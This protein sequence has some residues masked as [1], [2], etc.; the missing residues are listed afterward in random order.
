MQKVRNDSIIVIYHFSGLLQ[1]IGLSGSSGPSQLTRLG[2]CSS[3]WGV[4]G[5]PAQAV[6][7]S[8]GGPYSRSLSVD[9]VNAWA[10]NTPSICFSWSGPFVSCSFCGSAASVLDDWDGVVKSELDSLGVVEPES[11]TFASGDLATMSSSLAAAA[12]L[13]LVRALRLPCIIYINAAGSWGPAHQAVLGGIIINQGM[14]VSSSNSGMG[15]RKPLGADRGVSLVYWSSH[16]RVTRRGA[17]DHCIY[18]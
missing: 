9:G 18:I 4:P 14:D 2:S 5:S 11:S 8:P 17:Q 15:R 3:S 13:M 12:P 16:C 10:S 6:D 1:F 7:S